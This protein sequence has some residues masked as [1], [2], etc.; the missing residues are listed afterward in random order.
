MDAFIPIHCLRTDRSAS[1]IDLPAQIA[2]TCT[3]RSTRMLF[4]LLVVIGAAS[5]LGG[6]T[7]P[8]HQALYAGEEFSS[9][10]TYSH[11]FPADNVAACEAGRRALLSQGYIITESK[12]SL[13]KGSK[14][15][16]RNSD[17]HAEIE[18]TIVC[19][20][21]SVGSNASTVFVNAVRA[22]YSLKKSS[23]SASVGVGVLGSLSVPFGMS[24]DALVK[25]AGE[26]IQSE[27]FYGQFFARME[28]YIEVPKAQE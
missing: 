1:C 26:T 19:A 20:A 21:D 23:T 15:F 27:K 18:F 6:C 22:T 24:D 28:T 7:T 8:A 4:L 17:T 3:T 14:N 11:S 2:G 10:N 5:L 9:S 13:V 16:Q 25:V 12:P